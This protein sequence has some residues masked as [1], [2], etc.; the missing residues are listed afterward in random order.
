VAH[1]RNKIARKKNNQLY[2]Q[3]V[4]KKNVKKKNNQNNQLYPQEVVKKNA[5]RKLFKNNLKKIARL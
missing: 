1:N 2:P 5:R 3:E 4:V